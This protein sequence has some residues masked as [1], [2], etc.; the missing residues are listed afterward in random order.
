[1]RL[2]LQTDGT[3]TAGNASGINDGA[4]AVILM[5]A[6]AAKEKKVALIAKIVAIAQSGV[7]PNIMGTGP[8]PAVQLVV[9]QRKCKTLICNNSFPFSFSLNC[10][11]LVEES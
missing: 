4:A 11:V 6:K 8:I 5:S 1:M 10:C 7:D 3:I 9:S 2:W